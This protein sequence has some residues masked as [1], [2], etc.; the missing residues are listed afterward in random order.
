[1][2]EKEFL[3]SDVDIGRELKEKEQD[4]RDIG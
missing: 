2:K 4:E 1:M 3:I